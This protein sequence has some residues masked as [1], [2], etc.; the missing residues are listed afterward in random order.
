MKKSVLI[1]LIMTVISSQI[2]AQEKQFNLEKS[3]S[4]IEE[5]TYKGP[6]LN[7]ELVEEFLNE[8]I[9]IAEKNGIQLLPKIQDIH[10]IFVEPSSNVPAQLTGD[11]LGKIDVSKKLILLS[12]NCLLQYIKSNTF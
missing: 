12:K 2:F 5:G 8:Y 10:F 1:I 11:N 4:E 3:L 7:S 6:M 9:L